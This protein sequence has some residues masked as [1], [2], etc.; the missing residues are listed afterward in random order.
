VHKATE[1]EYTKH[2]QLLK[3]IKSDLIQYLYSILHYKGA[4]IK[5]HPEDSG[6]T[7]ANAY[8]VDWTDRL[9]GC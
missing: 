2:H 7:G 1:D 3:Q 6:T 8:R 9:N 5:K 4:K